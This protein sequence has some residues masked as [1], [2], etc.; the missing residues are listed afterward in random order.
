MGFFNRVFHCQHLFDIL[1]HKEVSRGSALPHLWSRI[2]RPSKWWT[3]AWWTIS[4]PSQSI[5]LPGSIYWLLPHPNDQTVLYHQS[6]LTTVGSGVPGSACLLHP[7]LDQLSLKSW[8][9]HGSSSAQL[10]HGNSRSVEWATDGFWHPCRRI[11]IVKVPTPNMWYGPTLL[12]DLISYTP[13]PAVCRLQPKH[14]CVLWPRHVPSILTPGLS[15]MRTP[16]PPHPP[17]T[18]ALSTA[19]LFRKGLSLVL[20]C[21]HIQHTAWYRIRA[22]QILV[23]FWIKQNRQKEKPSE[24]RG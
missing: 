22:Q 12:T 13:L 4:Y 10:H 5:H 14:S 7:K 9:S 16:F 18:L 2:S 19:S 23:L 3:S 15:S 8:D 6:R 1:L 17:A 21:P 24:W 11:L 20:R